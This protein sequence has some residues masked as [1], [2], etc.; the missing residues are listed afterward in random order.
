[1]MHACESVCVCVCL[2]VML[3][4]GYGCVTLCRATHEQ[5]I[6]NVEV[7]MEVRRDT[8]PVYRRH[9]SLTI[10]HCAAIMLPVRD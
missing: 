8:V 5:D 7:S 1:M 3:G 4:V 9:E 2:F 6:M 10:E